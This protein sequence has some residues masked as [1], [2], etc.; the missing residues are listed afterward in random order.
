MTLLHPFARY[1]LVGLLNTGFHAAVFLLFHSLLGMSQA[2]SNLAGFL[3]SVSLSFCLNA[4]FTF[5]SSRSWRRYWA[6]CGFMGLVSLSVGALGDALAW[7]PIATL[8]VF[9]AMSLVLGYAFARY[10]VFRRTV[11]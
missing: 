5:D 7:P 3:A 1:C 10:V 2:S 9:S 11:S 8:I 6:Y 4:R